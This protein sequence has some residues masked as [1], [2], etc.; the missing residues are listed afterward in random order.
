VVAITSSPQRVI[1][2]RKKIKLK[3]IEEITT[4]FVRANPP[5]G[6]NEE[7]PMALLRA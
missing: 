7:T 1:Y 6:L 3:K 4:I 5:P 2:E